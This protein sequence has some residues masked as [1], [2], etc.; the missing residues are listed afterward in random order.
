NHQ[1]ENI[2]K[3][4]MTS[5]AILDVMIGAVSM[6]LGVSELVHNGRWTLGWEV[7]R[8]RL[9]LSFVFS[10]ILAY[11]VMCLSVDRYLA[12]CKPFL[13]KRLPTRTAYVMI[14][15]SWIIPIAC[16]MIPVFSGITRLGVE[17]IIAC[18][19]KHDI[20]VTAY[21]I[22]AMKTIT[23]LLF[24]LPFVVTYTAYVFILL[25]SQEQEK[26]MFRATSQP[27][28]AIV[29]KTSPNK[30]A[31][32]IVGCMIACYTISWLPTWVL[33]LVISLEVHGVPYAW[34]LVCFWL[35]SSNA[36]LNPI[37]FCLNNSIR[38]TLFQLFFLSKYNKKN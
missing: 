9:P 2:T 21:N 28:R 15:L 7:C 19:E 38:Q 5:S 37:V 32:L 33:G 36:A 29:T 6:P 23:S 27:T 35:A 4:L 30:K 18:I 11:H 22:P 10:G 8:I 34:F 16:V 3:W 14:F 12:V 20:C 13:Y 26:V 25:A 17:H 1:T 31:N 24:Y